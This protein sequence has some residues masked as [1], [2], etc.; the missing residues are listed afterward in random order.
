MLKAED[1]FR[2]VEVNAAALVARAR[3]S[4]ATFMMTFSVVCSG[5]VKCQPEGLTSR[6][7]HS[8]YRVGIQRHGEDR[9]IANLNLDNLCQK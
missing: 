4:P 9:E 2:D 3:T 8:Q 6:N 7:H 1:D 5:Q